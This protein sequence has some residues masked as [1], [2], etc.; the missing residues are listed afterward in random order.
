[1]KEK[2][3]TY[4]EREEKQANEVSKS[5]GVMKPDDQKKAFW[6]L[7]GMQMAREEEKVG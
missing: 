5:L 4:S 7:K 2:E 1:M 6:I 3:K